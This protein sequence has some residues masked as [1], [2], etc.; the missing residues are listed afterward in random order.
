MVQV[1]SVGVHNF[2]PNFNIAGLLEIVAVSVMLEA[3][4]ILLQ[5]ISFKE[6]T[7]RVIQCSKGL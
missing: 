4:Q 3:S 6:A 5:G 1:S 7:Q 2:V